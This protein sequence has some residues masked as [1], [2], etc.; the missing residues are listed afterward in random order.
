M[1]T[2]VNPPI[3]PMKKKTDAKHGFGIRIFETEGI[4]PD[5]KRYSKE[6]VFERD[7]MITRTIHEPE[8]RHRAKNRASTSGGVE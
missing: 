8:P 4:A 3:H 5:R 7:S 1:P 2:V 6:T